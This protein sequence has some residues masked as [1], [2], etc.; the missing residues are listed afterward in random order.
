MSVEGCVKQTER[1][2]NGP[3]VTRGV[4][5]SWVLFPPRGLEIDGMTGLHTRALLTEHEERD[6]TFSPCT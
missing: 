1:E 4:G 5:M 6:H 3:A 2:G